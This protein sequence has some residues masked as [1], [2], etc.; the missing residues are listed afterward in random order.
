M[1]LVLRDPSLLACAA[2]P[3]SWVVFELGRQSQACLPTCQLGSRSLQ[4]KGHRTVL[5]FCV[6]LEQRILKSGQEALE[7]CLWAGDRRTSRFTL[8]VGE[9]K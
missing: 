1:T 5:S 6:Y 2:S 7:P 9:H 4:L 8:H 3:G